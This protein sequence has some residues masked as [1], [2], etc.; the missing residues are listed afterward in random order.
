[1][2]GARFVLVGSGQPEYSRRVRA[3]IDE[4]GLGARVVLAGQRADMPA[5]Y[6]AL[7]VL[8]LNSAYGE[9]FPNVV[10]E[11]LACGTPCVVT[12]V[13]D[14]ALLAN[15]A[16]AAGLVVPPGKPEE[17]AV[18]LAEMLGRADRQGPEVQRQALAAVLAYTPEALAQ[19]TETL[20]EQLLSGSARTKG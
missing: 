1:M 4:L 12:D 11:A 2:P 8:C 9:G 5:V 13:G 20:L 7:D 18:A 6:S 17:L 3:L 16:G 14:A 10:A 15:A 19:R